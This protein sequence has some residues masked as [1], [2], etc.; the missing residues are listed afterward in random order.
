VTV[1]YD[2]RKILIVPEKIA[3]FYFKYHISRYCVQ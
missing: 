2:H 3:I 1:F